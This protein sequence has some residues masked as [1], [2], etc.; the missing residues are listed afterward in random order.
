MESSGGLNRRTGKPEPIMASPKESEVSQR[1]R[2]SK[3]RHL[4]DIGAQA[5]HQNLMPEKVDG[6]QDRD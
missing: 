1:G 3:L 6:R 5:F 2:E 4:E